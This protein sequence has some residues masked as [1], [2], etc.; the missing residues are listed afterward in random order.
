MVW[1]LTRH[2]ST[3]TTGSVTTGGS[4][5]LDSTVAQAAQTDIIGDGVNS[6]GRGGG[7]AGKSG[8]VSSALREK[9]RSVTG[10]YETIN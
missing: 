1:F 9:K 8:G 2:R 4:D 6:I 10:T 7:R 3:S 5:A